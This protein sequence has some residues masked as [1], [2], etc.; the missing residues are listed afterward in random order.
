M[1]AAVAAALRSPTAAGPSRRSAAPG[2]SSIPFDRRRSFAFGS[3]K[4]G[5]ASGSL[6]RLK[7]RRVFVL[8]LLDRK[9]KWQFG[10]YHLQFVSFFVACLSIFWFLYPC[11]W[12]HGLA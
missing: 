12:R 7:L 11:L 1:E 6:L 2:A 8:L 5:G 3:I 4:V 10:S 9:E